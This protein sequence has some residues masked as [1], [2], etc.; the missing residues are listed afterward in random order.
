MKNLVKISLCSFLLF[1]NFGVVYADLPD[2]VYNEIR[3]D[4]EDV[5]VGIVEKSDYL[6]FKQYTCY[7]ILVIESVERSWNSDHIGEAQTLTYN[8]SGKG[9]EITG[10]VV[11][12]D[13]IAP[14]SKIKVYKNNTEIVNGGIEF[15]NQPPEELYPENNEGENE[16]D[17]IPLILI[18]G[19]IIA[20]SFAYYGRKDDKKG[21]NPIKIK[22]K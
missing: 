19:V 18:V 1:L 7:L 11:W 15:I 17:I 2:Y 13:L 5:V 21:K 22:K 12:Y 9:D 10:G 3:N 14:G 6:E 8:C 16:D 20:L 4:A